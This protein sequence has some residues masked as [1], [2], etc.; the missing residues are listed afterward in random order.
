[1]SGWYASWFD[2]PYYHMLYKHRDDEEARLFLTHL[3]Q[4]IHLNRGTQILDKAC[5]RGRH[6]GYLGKL[7]FEVTGTDLS[8]NN[9]KH[10]RRYFGKLAHFD[11]QDMQQVYKSDYFDVVLSL[12]TSFG[13]FE[14]DAEN[15]HVLDVTFQELKPGGYFVFDYLNPNWVQ[16]HLKEKESKTIHRTE[17]SIRRNID[18]DCIVKDIHVK[19]EEL[20]LNFQE[21]VKAYG[22]EDLSKML[23][24]SGFEAHSVYGDYTFSAFDAEHSPRTILIV[25]KPWT[26]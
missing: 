10:A 4:C 21:K 18:Q 8:S 23:I 1:M 9:I 16:A 2:S 22:L 11:I 12:F 7:G 6:A 15:Q 26:V 14:T 20:S 24:N 5:G 3:T 19:D 17:F 25:K 13:Y